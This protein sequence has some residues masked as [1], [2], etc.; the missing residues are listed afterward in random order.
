MSLNFKNYLSLG[1][2]RLVTLDRFTLNKTSRS[3]ETLDSGT[4]IYHYVREN[5]HEKSRIHLRIDPDGTGTLI[6][7]ANRVMHLNPTAA[8]MAYLILEGKREQE[9]IQSLRHQYRVSENQ[10]SNDLS[11][12]NLQ[13]DNLIRPDGACPIHELDLESIMP[14]SARP[15]APYRMDLALTY[16][17]NNDCAHC[18]NARERNFPELTTKQWILILDQLWS[19]GVPHIVFTGGEATLRNDLPELIA[20]AESNGQ[21]TGLNTNARRLADKKYVQ[22]LVDA[23]LD[24]VQITVESCDEQIH[25]EM[26]RAK[27]AFKQTIQGLK[28]VLATRLYVMT[29]TTMLRTNVHKIPDTLD[30]LADLCVPTVG[31][32]ALI[33]AGHGLSVG[34]GLHERELQPILDIAVKK[35]SEHGQR[36][37]WYTPTQYCNFDPTQSNLGIK[38]CTASFY[39]MCIESNGNVLPCQSYYFPLGNILTDAWDSIWNHKLSIQLRERHGLPAKCEGCPVVSECGGGCPLTFEQRALTGVAVSKGSNVSTS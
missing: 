7:N 2:Q 1:L 3:L 19:L 29:N 31:L 21:I 24:H 4:K 17:C 11:I 32:N 15:S 35:T 36:L 13:L 39:S 9:I 14:F 38:G 8:L 28:N 16:R 27:G 26:M 20:H 25:D 5:D 12:F 10:A 33:Y 37:I 22:Q 23:G 6:V 18:Y 30:F 34:T